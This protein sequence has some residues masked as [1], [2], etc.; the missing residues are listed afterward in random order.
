MANIY[1]NE[2]AF[3]KVIGSPTGGSITVKPSHYVLGAY[4]SRYSPSIL[5][6]LDYDDVL[7]EFDEA[8]LDLADYIDFT[9]SPSVLDGA[10]DTEDI[11]NAAITTEK[12]HP[13]T[14][15]D[16]LDQVPEPPVGLTTIVEVDTENGIET[17]YSAYKHQFINILPPNNEFSTLEVG[18]EHIRAR[19]AFWPEAGIRLTNRI[20]LGGDGST[21]TGLPCIQAGTG[22]PDNGDSNQDGSLWIRTDASSASAYLYVKIAGTYVAIGA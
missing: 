6:T 9:Q 4:F 17:E 19:I 14:I 7:D 22:V 12:L 5:T 3:D 10:I 16:I 15:Q 1:K 18:T 2:S 11:T 21:S 20:F 8:E 13:D